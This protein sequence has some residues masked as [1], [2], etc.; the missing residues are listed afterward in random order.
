MA[1]DE[2]PCATWCTRGFG[3]ASGAEAVVVADAIRY[4]T[5]APLHDTP[6]CSRLGRAVCAAV[7]DVA[8]VAAFSEGEGTDADGGVPPHRPRRRLSSPSA[9]APW[10][11][12]TSAASVCCV[13]AEPLPVAPAGNPPSAKFGGRGVFP[14]APSDPA[15]AGARSSRRWQLPKTLCPN[16]G[17]GFFRHTVP[18]AG[19]HRR[20]R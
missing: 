17:K 6:T 5:G 15:D 9:M 4:T 19:C 1:T 12:P 14:A 11:T 18:G 8:D 16:L 7:A 10:R 2:T 3:G 20:R 13:Q